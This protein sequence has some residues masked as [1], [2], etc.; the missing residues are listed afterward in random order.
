MV[1][2]GHQI[3]DNQ[4]Q[5]VRLSGTFGGEPISLSQFYDPDNPITITGQTSGVTA[6]VIGFSLSG[7][8]ADEPM[9]FV[10]YVSSGASGDADPSSGVFNIFFFVHETF[11]IRHIKFQNSFR[12][13]Q[14]PVELLLPLRFH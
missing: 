1:I 8:Q 10:N 9:L 13:L 7:D 12:D 5:A 14:A 11:N 3:Y 4:Y 6:E 2:P